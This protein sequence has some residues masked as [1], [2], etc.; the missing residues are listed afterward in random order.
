MYNEQVLNKC[1]LNKKLS[2]LFSTASN[3]NMNQM[4]E[5]MGSNGE[6]AD[7][8]SEITDA[9]NNSIYSITSSQASQSDE[10]SMSE[11]ESTVRYTLY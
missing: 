5:E 7:E 9:I 2:L 11:P 8:A 6:S 4:T 3:I 10:E 1:S